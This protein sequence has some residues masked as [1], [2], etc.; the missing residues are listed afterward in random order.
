MDTVLDRGEQKKRWRRP[1]WGGLVDR[2]VSWWTEV[3]RREQRRHW[4]VERSIQ[5]IRERLLK[6]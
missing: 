2:G 6:N 3:K 5:R 1:W 4:L